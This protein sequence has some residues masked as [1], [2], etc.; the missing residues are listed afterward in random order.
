M[1]EIKSD[2]PTIGAEVAVV[3]L[4]GGVTKGGR[5]GLARNNHVLGVPAIPIES[6]TDAVV[7]EP[8]VS[9]EVEGLDHLPRD[10]A[11]HERRSVI[12]RDLVAVAAD[13]RGLSARKDGLVKV[14]F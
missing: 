14:L 8:E 3:A 4:R 10:V 6:E 2:L 9:S 7:P 5:K 1:A 11:V 13:S 12:L